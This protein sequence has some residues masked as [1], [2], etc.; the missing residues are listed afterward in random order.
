MDRG[1][2]LRAH[3]CE[4]VGDGVFDAELGNVLLDL[5]MPAKAIS[6]EVNKAGLVDI[7]GITGQQ[8]VHGEDVKKLDVS[9]AALGELARSRSF[10]GSTKRAVVAPSDVLYGVARMFQSM[11]EA[12]PEEFQIFRTVGEAKHWLGVS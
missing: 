8:N 6:C 7:L 1:Q 4:Q 9:T 11:H 12:A 10:S 5:T 3:I 2:S